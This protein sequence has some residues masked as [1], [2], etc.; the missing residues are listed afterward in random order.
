MGHLQRGKIMPDDPQDP[1]DG[2]QDPA[3]PEPTGGSEGNND[4]ALADLRAE[5]DTYKTTSE[6]SLS[7]LNTKYTSSTNTVNSLNTQ[8]KTA[9]DRV[10]ELEPL[11]GQL[12][13][14]TKERDAGVTRFQDIARGALIKAGVDE[15]KLKDKSLVEL[16]AMQSVVADVSQNNNSNANLGLDGGNTTQSPSGGKTPLEQAALE[17]DNLR[18]NARTSNVQVTQ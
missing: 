18:K 4:S 2:N 1:Q 8:L 11:Q 6:A 10:A 7:E 17:M 3:P 14:M 15:E 13:A 5:F 16:E 12:D 9:T